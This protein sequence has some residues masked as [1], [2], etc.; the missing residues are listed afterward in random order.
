LHTLFQTVTAKKKPGHAPGFFYLF[1]D[2]LAAEL[3]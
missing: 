2:V 1:D 3:I